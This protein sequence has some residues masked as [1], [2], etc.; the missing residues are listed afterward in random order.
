MSASI[1]P[2]CGTQGRPKKRTR[3]SIW[4]ELVLWLCFIVPGLIYS[5]WRLTTRESVCPGC[6]SP[7][8]IPLGSPRGKQLAAQFNT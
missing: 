2:A 7:G 8:M 6:G 5:V 1:C 3:G 4:I